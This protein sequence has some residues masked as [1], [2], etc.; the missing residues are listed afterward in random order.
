MA[1]LSARG[2]TELVRLQ[3]E[4]SASDAN[5]LR[6]NGVER[7]QYT[8]TL[9]SDGRALKKT[10]TWFTPGPYD[11]GKVRRH[12]YGWKDMGKVTQESSDPARFAAHFERRGYRKEG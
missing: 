1:K 11:R 9:M 8:V 2:R 5:N 4:V 10:V 3:K 12:D 7:E 6:A